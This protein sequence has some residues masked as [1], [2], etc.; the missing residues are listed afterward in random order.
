MS[1]P[2]KVKPYSFEDAVSDIMDAARNC[3]VVNKDYPSDELEHQVRRHLARYANT[4]MN[5]A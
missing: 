5:G 2:A 4:L 1:A 3:P